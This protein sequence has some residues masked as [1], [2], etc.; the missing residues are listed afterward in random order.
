LFSSEGIS[1]RIRSP[2]VAARVA[3]VFGAL[4]ALGVAPSFVSAKTYS[5]TTTIATSETWT[6]A[7]S[8]VQINGVTVTV[9]SGVT[10]TIDPGVRVVGSNTSSKLRVQ[11]VLNVNGSAGSL[12]VFTSAADSAPGQWSGIEF[13]G[14]SGSI[15]YAQ[16][17]YANYTA[18]ID[19]TAASGAVTIE[20]STIE[21]NARIGVRVSATT[22]VGPLL[23]V[24]RSMVRRN[25][26]LGGANERSGV[27]AVS[28]RV[29]IEDSALWRNTDDGLEVVGVNASYVGSPSVV[30]GTSIWHNGR[31]GVNIVNSGSAVGKTPDGVASGSAPNAIY[32]NGTFTFGPTDGW[33]QVAVGVA[34][35]DGDWSG[36]WWGAPVE[37]QPCPGGAGSGT[38]Y[39]SFS[40]P[41]LQ[42]SP[43]VQIER[44]PVTASGV[45]VG[46]TIV[47][48]DAA[49]TVRPAAGAEPDLYF[50][51]PPAV[52]GGV[53]TE[54]L[55]GCL[56][57]AVK[58]AMVAL[59]VK[60]MVK[61]FVGRPVN[62][63][64]G[65]LSEAFTDVELP[66]PGIGFSW[67]RSYS[68]RD[69]TVGAL[70]RGW[71]WPYDATLT[72][73]STSPVEVIEYRSG[74]GQRT[75]F[76]RRSGSSGAAT[77][78]A[79]GFD[80]VLTR[81]S[82]GTYELVAQGQSKWLF[83]SSLKLTS[84]KDRFGPA[85]TL[86]YSSGR[87]SSITDSAG[88]AMAV[89]W[90]GANT[91]ITRV[92]L[93]DARYVDYSYTGNLLTGVR[94]LRGESW[95]LGYN[96]ANLLESIEDPEGRFTVQNI[97]Y[98]ASARVLSEEDGVGE[99]IGY[100]YSTDGEYALTTVTQPGRGDWLYRAID[101]V[102]ISVTDP[103]GNVTG[104]RYDT[105]G[106]TNQVIDARGLV[107]KSTYDTAG[108]LRTET[109]PAP[110]SYVVSR[111][112]NAANDLLTET[113]GR[114]H[115]TTYSYATSTIS[116][117]I[118]AGQLSQVT[119]RAGGVEKYKYNTTTGQL[120]E[121]E[122]ARGKKTA[123]A[124]DAAGNL[125]S[126]TTP[127]GNVTTMTYDT[128]GRLLT[129]R[130]PRGNAVIPPAGYRTEFAYDDGDA[131]TLVRDALG[132]ETTST[133]EDNG[134]LSTVTRMEGVTARTTTYEY[135]PANRLWKTTDPRGLVEERLY[136]PDSSLASI[137]TP[138]G[139]TTYNY[140]TAGRLVEI[141]E[142][143]GNALGATPSDYTTTY[144]LDENGNRLTETHPD[145]GTVTT[146]YDEVNRPVAWQDANAITTSV[147]YDANNNIVQSTD[148]LAEDATATFDNLDRQLTATDERGKTTTTA[149]WP[150][151]EVKSVT[152]PL[153]N[154]TS[155]T[156]DN[157]GRVATMVE[158]RGNAMGATPADYTWTYAYDE[159]GN[160]T[161]TT[162]PLGNDT[163]TAYSPVDTVTAVTDPNNHT[164]SYTYDDLNRLWKVT[165]EAAGGTGTLDTV[166]T[167]DAS[168]NLAQ[169]I[170]PNARTTTW[171]WSL[172]G[173]LD[174]R[175]TPIGTYRYGY[176]ANG[177]LT[178]LEKPSGT[179]T[180]T[181]ADGTISYAYDRA[182]RQTSI[183]YSDGTPTVTRT[184]DAGGRLETMSDD[185]G[186]VDYTFDD[187]DRLATIDRTSTVT[188]LDGAISYTRDVAG[189]ITAR[190]FPGSVATAATYDDDGRA[191]TVTAAGETTTITYDAAGNPTAI[192][193]PAT[194]GWVQH[195]SYDEAGRLTE[196]RNVLNSVYF[197]GG[198]LDYDD[199]G[200]PIRAALTRGATTSYEVRQYD[201]R[202]RLTAFCAQASILSTT[203]AG[204]S[205]ELH[206]AY[207]KVSAITQA[208]RSA[209]YPQ[210]GTTDYAYNAAGQLDYS[211]RSLTVNDYAYDPDGNTIT[212]GG[213]TYTYDLADQLVA[214]TDGATTQTA[215]WDGD[216]NRLTT[217]SNAS[218]DIAFITDPFAL[219]GLAETNVERDPT[220]GAVIRSYGIAPYGRTTLV[221][222]NGDPHYYHLAADVG[223]PW[224]LVDQTGTDE[225]AYNVLP[226]GDLN[227]ANIFVGTPPDNPILNDGQYYDADTGLYYMRNRM[228]D[229]NTS[230]F[231]ETDPLENPLASAFE[232][233]YM[234]VGG[235]PTTQF[236]PTGLRGIR[237]PTVCA[238]FVCNRGGDEATITGL[239]LT[240]FG[241]AA[242]HISGIADV[243]AAYQDAR[244][245][246]WKGFAFNGALVAC[247]FIP[248]A[249]GLRFVGPAA[250]A[251]D[252][253][254]RVGLDGKPLWTAGGKGFLRNALQHFQDHG[255]QFGAQNALDYV[256]QA[257]QFLHNPPSTVLTRVRANGDVVRYDPVSNTL[258][259]MDKS[260][261]PRTMFKPDPAKH[262]YPTNREY[263]DAQ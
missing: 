72:I 39:L 90:N 110:L 12:V 157:D 60:A 100:A 31:Y 2:R 224:D 56:P 6:L 243:T 211:T 183:S 11:G 166:Y 196:Y 101:N 57:C 220:T 91:L 172:T 124:Y 27:R 7:D 145:A 32:D 154:K 25:G 35:P 147:V 46:G 256:R 74:T 77:F 20:D 10:L 143:N 218:A 78:Y 80:G 250:K 45:A 53:L 49:V 102:L 227:P 14:G 97:T 107:T 48:A 142:P 151:G 228:Y 249:R 126:V 22:G 201:A 192:T 47:C 129:R 67:T 248:P 149:Y 64:T 200:N 144:T 195:R 89:T 99:T 130:D 198:Q 180:L 127:L 33:L 44:G 140:D 54:Q 93:P 59:S 226:Y 193:F 215:T 34:R 108:N 263:F 58:K 75:L 52:F 235:R 221:D 158:A 245:G 114:G 162:D 253:V 123:Y 216:G 62:T 156:L 232:D 222:A 191:A 94:D 16:V 116:G 117:D 122:D 242:A 42:P 186:T 258:G 76:Q 165:P 109:S 246:D 68:S 179:S 174:E 19:I 148:G 50:D 111:T 214:A 137:E 167:Y 23:T 223:H 1:L 70:G 240:P 170:D 3:L 230:R 244:A 171:D 55:F 257:H 189:N 112:Y 202:D 231:L 71:S 40:A 217:T 213:W 29:V 178:S 4:L 92:T 210:P 9:G 219:T 37:E 96:A 79:R 119:D 146:T 38:G 141:V 254:A 13:A 173:R 206:Y 150:T 41:P 234:Y 188:G 225:V 190:T 128:A 262:G 187:A 204:A 255:A 30:T 139:T 81:S 159:A 113:D 182:G 136:D 15:A 98:D 8:P 118:L 120:R 104:Y 177:N 161:T 26:S 115:T 73:V 175:T 153:G 86:A 65:S 212:N 199:A 95:I 205:E 18:A 106:R 61:A 163:Q 24:R 233:A 21:Q 134:L 51:A 197:G 208:I 241:T 237:L 160:Q 84:V 105:R 83:N 28:A 121:I 185:G 36:T 69:S 152:T 169:R 135:D 43:A 125:A 238:T 103:E 66:G 132:N 168:G 138:D 63:T 239:S 17:K 194:N 252:G 5:S 82:G 229:P 88:R 203:C 131:V 181:A 259:V 236:D 133:Y 261:A 207:D 209:G 155:W 247:N 184:Y 164:T 87:V 260:G 176:D 251:L 85:T